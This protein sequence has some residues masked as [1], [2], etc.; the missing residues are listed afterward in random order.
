MSQYKIKVNVE[1]IEC[2]ESEPNNV[3]TR[4]KDGSFT[5]TINEQDAISID[6]CESS[7]LQTAY[8]MIRDALSK[9]LTEVSKK[10]SKKRAIKKK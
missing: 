1:L 7:V 2:D 5:M 3:P 4:Q 8:P 6:K 10:T 9:H